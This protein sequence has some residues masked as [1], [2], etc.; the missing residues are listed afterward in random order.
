MNDNSRTSVHL[1]NPINSIVQYRHGQGW[2]QCLRLDMWLSLWPN[3]PQY[4]HKHNPVNFIIRTEGFNVFRAGSARGRS[5]TLL[6]T[7]IKNMIDIALS[8]QSL[9]RWQKL[10]SC[11]GLGVLTAVWLIAL[12]FVCGDFRN[13]WRILYPFTI[14]VPMATLMPTGLC[15]WV[16]T[17]KLIFLR[18]RNVKAFEFEHGI[19]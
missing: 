10:I 9:L 12:A 17:F 7:I 19:N 3:W 18:L 6:F 1:A 15:A 4:L 5:L 16:V 13:W 11:L 2:A 8:S 14:R